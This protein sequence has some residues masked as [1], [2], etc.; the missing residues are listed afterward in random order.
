M[1]VDIE[2]LKDTFQVGYETFRQSRL[3]ATEAWD[4]YNNRHYNSEQLNVLASRGQPAETFNIVKLFGRML[5]GY[6]STV[7][8]TVKVNPQQYGD[9]DVA[10]LLNDTANWVLR[11]NN[12]DA[13]GDFIK[14]DGILSGLFC[15]YVNVVDN[16]KTDQFG[17]KMYDIELEAVPSNELILDP[18]SRK[19]DYSDARFV[20]RF[21]WISEDEFVKMFGKAKLKQV[22][23]Y[24]NHLGEDDTDFSFR[25]GADFY[26]RYRKLNNYLIV[27][28]VIRDESDKYWSVFWSGDI[29]LTKKEIT[30]KKVKFPYRVVKLHD[31]NIA[32]YYGIFRDVVESQKAIN[33]ALLQIQLAVNS[34]KALVQSESVENI[35]QFA[36]A[37]NR[38][39]AVI[40]VNDLQGIRIENL[41]QDIAQ[42]YMIID[43]AF[44]RIQRILS[45]ND[46][47]L[48]MAFASDSGRKVKLQQNAS[49]MA[50]RYITVKLELLYRLIGWD[51]IHLIQQYFKAHQVLRIV[52]ESV[53]ERWIQINAPAL[54]P[55]GRVD[56][57]GMPEMQ[58]L[59]EAQTNPETG[60]LEE[61][62]EGNFIIAPVNLAETALE[63]ADVDIE[64]V[65][66]AYNDED[67][68]N[69]L[70][71][72][73]MLSGAG[74]AFLQATNPAGY[75]KAM[76]LT[77]RSMKT[78]YSPD[79]SQI[80]ENTAM[81]LGADQQMAMQASLQAPQGG[82]GRM[83]QQNKLPQNTN[84]E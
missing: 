28:T 69:Q 66:S 7:V 72:E 48:G 11:K 70:M 60:E 15:T 32:E 10:A 12:F 50:L 84:E 14:L 18:M 30:Y 51:V 82:Q 40:P 46:S 47:F 55:T 64:I 77:V 63:F 2:T 37:F 49:I 13:E 6:Y 57:M 29:I 59:L 74:G 39:N 61:D 58:P 24:D 68:K 78:K 31:S 27:H 75:A 25:Y 22:Q 36:A 73:T 43:R 41:S 52:D 8:N 83:S 53:G 17:R 44:D 33:Q 71:M 38:V 45:I 65:T 16:G 76:A 21:K 20:H 80:F 1:K 56:Q 26:G 67:E 81:M 35:E 5:L 62:E 54:V 3:D 79:I 34:S 42:Q 4:L 23:E 9:I 19:V